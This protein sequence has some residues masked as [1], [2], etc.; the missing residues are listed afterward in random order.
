MGFSDS[1]NRGPLCGIQSHGRASSSAFGSEK[2]LCRRVSLPRRLRCPGAPGPRLPGGTDSKRTEAQLSARGWELHHQ[3]LQCSWARA[4]GGGGGK[5]GVCIRE[6]D[7]RERLPLPAPH[8]RMSGSSTWALR[9]TLGRPPCSTSLGRATQVLPI[10]GARGR[11]SGRS[12]SAGLWRR[13]ALRKRGTQQPAHGALWRGRVHLSLGTTTAGSPWGRRAG[14][15]GSCG[16]VGRHVGSLAPGDLSRPEQERFLS[17]VLQGSSAATRGGG[18]PMPGPE[19]GR[20][21]VWC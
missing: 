6:G 9:V 17:M 18:A 10:L 11:S 7:G 13:R 15:A 19:A 14:S 21:A 2:R 1:E 16:G 8:L 20:H 5:E 3:H 12:R 4:W